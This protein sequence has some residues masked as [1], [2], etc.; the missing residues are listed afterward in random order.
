MKR[1]FSLNSTFCSRRILYRYR[2]YRLRHL[3][4]F[5]RKKFHILMRNTY[6]CYYSM[7][8]RID[9]NIYWNER[10]RQINRC[11]SANVYQVGCEYFA[12]CCGSLIVRQSLPYLHGIK[13]RP[14]APP[15][16]A[17]ANVLFSEIIKNRYFAVDQVIIFVWNQNLLLYDG[18][19]SPWENFRRWSADLS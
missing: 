15:P 19:S 1:M 13:G 7:S 16:C 14:G 9:V 4:E 8:K 5:S 2:D 18:I 10:K 12:V 3:M 17:D 6:L 11:F